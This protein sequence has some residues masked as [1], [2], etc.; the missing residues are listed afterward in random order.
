MCSLQST[1]PTADNLLL[2]HRGSFLHI[3]GRKERSDEYLGAPWIGNNGYSWL[4][5]QGQL[6]EATKMGARLVATNS[7]WATARNAGYGKLQ[8]E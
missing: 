1:C 7:P 4:L 5:G 2:F 3:C 6:A 8:Q